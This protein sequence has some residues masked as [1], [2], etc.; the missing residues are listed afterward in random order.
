MKFPTRETPDPR[1]KYGEIMSNKDQE[2][3]VRSHGLQCDRRVIW[4]D[5][6]VGTPLYKRFQ[7]K[8]V[9]SQS[10]IIS[11]VVTS[12]DAFEIAPNEPQ[13]LFPG[14]TLAFDVSFNP[15]T[16]IDYSGCIEISLDSGLLKVPLIASSQK[17][18]VIV[19]DTILSYGVCGVG[20]T[21][22]KSFFLLNTSENPMD[23]QW[24][25]SDS[26]F[27]LSSRTSTILPGSSLDYDIFFRPTSAGKYSAH[28]VGLI[29]FNSSQKKIDIFLEA[30]GKYPS[31][32]IESNHL[33]FGVLSVDNRVHKTL[34]LS[35]TGKVKCVWA[36]CMESNL[37]EK[38]PF[39]VQPLRGEI[40]PGSS[41]SLVISCLPML[42][43]GR[44]FQIFTIS[45][46]YQSIEL[47]VSASRAFGLENTAELINSTHGSRPSLCLGSDN[48]V[49]C[50]R[51][52]PS[53]SALQS[54]VE[55]R[56]GFGCAVDFKFNLNEHFG[57]KTYDVAPQCGCI[58]AN[59][60]I[61]LIFSHPS[62]PLGQQIFHFPCH[63][64]LQ[65]GREETELVSF[66]TNGCM[67][68][69][70]F[71]PP[72]LEVNDAQIYERPSTQ[73]VLENNSDCALRYELSLEFSHDSL[74][75]SA[76][77]NKMSG[78]LLA[79]THE[80]LT[81][82]FYPTTA[83]NF[84]FQV[85]CHVDDGSDSRLDCSADAPTCII[86]VRS[87]HPRIWIADIQSTLESKRNAW[88]RF[89]IDKLNCMLLDEI[90]LDKSGLHDDSCSH[91]DASH[92]HR[93][94]FGTHMCSE[95][96]SQVHLLLHNPEQFPV[97]WNLTCEVDMQLEAEY[98]VRKIDTHT[99]RNYRIASHLS[100][101]FSVNSRG[102]TIRKGETSL[103]VIKINHNHI[104]K[105]DMN[106]SLCVENGP[107]INLVFIVNNVTQGP[108]LG[109]VSDRESFYVEKNSSPS[110]QYYELKN[111]SP[112]ELAVKIEALPLGPKNGDSKII[113]VQQNIVLPPLS[114]RL[115]PWTFFAGLDFNKPSEHSVCISDGSTSSHV[116]FS[117]DSDDRSKIELKPQMIFEPL[118][119]AMTL[120][121]EFL[122]FGAVAPM[123]VNKKVCFLQNRSSESFSFTWD[124]NF[125]IQSDTNFSVSI[126]PHGGTIEPNEELKFIVSM[127]VGT[128]T[129]SIYVEIP[130]NVQNFH[131]KMESSRIYLVLS[132]NSSQ[133]C[134]H[135]AKS[136]A[137]LK[138]DMCS[139]VTIPFNSEYSVIPVL[140]NILR[141][142]LLESSQDINFSEASLSP[143]G[144]QKS[145]EM[146]AL[147][148][149]S[150]IQM[151]E[152]FLEEG[153]VL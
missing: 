90:E 144:D 105:W 66:V 86:S 19:S 49:I 131:S 95:S 120:R 42:L 112:S 117:I 73:F 142:T 111:R 135:S 126:Y 59:E 127:H 57:E 10:Q 2:W 1:A 35:N 44:M 132:G 136:F 64:T 21:A 33:Q 98:S 75:C 94:D 102:G 37:F 50:M 99:C 8:N 125:I 22:T 77:L 87:S 20:S 34:S 129:Q 65:N 12:C 4:K 76:E 55:L 89:R 70:S 130:C 122:S 106:A 113:F 96:C 47:I 128:P 150:F 93:F 24:T 5:W 92:V 43:I 17:D 7:I 15:T 36:I 56:N 53:G 134:A 9:G 141:E 82:H 68:Q 52:C 69:I 51:S 116:H 62:V 32:I 26:S 91:S 110:V 100:E 119:Q 149:S 71:H 41:V 81:I 107:S 39:D 151:I 78:E 146:N 67:P 139:R 108:I 14:M 123:S 83:G 80:M 138:E 72:R 143:D 30:L 109:I 152:Y 147:Q 3:S 101:I 104:G 13:I 103:V 29:Q 16:R 74:V 6:N 84:F 48:N 124:L 25:L 11:C 58:A 85:L 60:V 88:S 46:E 45:S 31:L 148:S 121:P 23:V 40:L 79:H 114:S 97:S 153:F 28:L 27:S 137:S 61:D 140:S 115:I 145:L 133:L 18:S 118:T 63:I 54:Q 38:C